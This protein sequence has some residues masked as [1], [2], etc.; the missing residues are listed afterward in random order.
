[1]ILLVK[2]KDIR[3]YLRRKLKINFKDSRIHKMNLVS[4]VWALIYIVRLK[5]R[6]ISLHN[7]KGEIIGHTIVSSGDYRH[8]NKFKWHLNYCGYAKGTI[9]NKEWGLNRY[10]EINSKVRV[11]HR[12]NKKLDN[13]RSNLRPLKPSED[14][15][16]SKRKGTSSKYHGVSLLKRLWQARIQVKIDGEIKNLR[17][18]YKNELHAAYQYNLWV[19]QYNLTTN[20]KN[21]ILV[22]ND[23]IPWEN[24]KG[25][26]LPK[27]VRKNGIRYRVIISKKSYGT[28]LTVDEA[29]KVRDA[30]LKIQKNTS[31]KKQ[32]WSLCY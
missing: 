20:P 10:V 17:A 6:K 29:I 24:K 15:N 13:R 27:Y 11:D 1:M 14:R 4:V 3:F 18:F 32:G 30:E 7:I 9:K 8:L 2:C 23:F 28:Y 31:I 21:K 12:N 19:E 16:Y 22:S 25:I 26:E 5:G